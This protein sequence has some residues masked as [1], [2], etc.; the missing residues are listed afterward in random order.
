M[1]VSTVP[2]PSSL[3]PPPA[4]RLP[5]PASRPR[6]HP[7]IRYR[8]ER[9]QASVH[10]S[11]HQARMSPQKTGSSSAL[12][13]LSSQLASAVET[14]ANSVVAIHARR[15]IPSSGIVWRE[16]IVVSASHTVRRDDEIPVTLPDGDST[17]AKVAGRD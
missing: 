13:E 8:R 11:L 10:Q 6:S 14:A 2:F 4:S 1:T 12:S 17:V 9:H 3:F 5:P 16:G 15:R 7:F